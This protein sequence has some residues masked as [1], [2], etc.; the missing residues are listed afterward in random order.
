MQHLQR[1]NGET[2]DLQCKQDLHCENAGPAIGERSTCNRRMQHLRW[3]KRSTCEVR[4]GS[5]CVQTAS[6]FATF[7]TK[8]PPSC[9]GRASVRRGT[10]SAK[11]QVSRFAYIHIVACGVRS[12]DRTLCLLAQWRKRETHTPVDR[13]NRAFH[14]K[15]L[16]CNSQQTQQQLF[17]NRLASPIRRL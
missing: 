6:G 13:H 5:G 4:T 8:P 7:Y 2:L 17:L 3:E 12:T 1:E 14:A 15:P 10:R 9:F 16:R 11:Q